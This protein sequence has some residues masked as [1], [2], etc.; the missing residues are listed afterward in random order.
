MTQNNVRES[1]IHISDR[2]EQILYFEG[3]PRFEM[4]FLNRAVVDDK[5]LR[6]VTLQRTADNKYQ[7][8]LVDGPEELAGDLSRADVEHVAVSYR[9]ITE[10]VEFEAALQRENIAH[11]AMLPAFVMFLTV[12]AVIFLGDRFRAAFDVKEANL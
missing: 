3:E 2:S 9:D 4:K 5:N 10:R 12:L 11:T 8:L 7:R 1:L 6:V